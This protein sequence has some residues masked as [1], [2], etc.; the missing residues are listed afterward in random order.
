MGAPIMKSFNFK[1]QGN[2]VRG[3]AALVQEG[4]NESVY[5]NF[6]V[7]GF[8]RSDRT[9]AGRG[10]GGSCQDVDRS[11]R[12]HVY[13]S[14]QNDD[15]SGGFLFSHRGHDVHGGYEEAGAHRGE[16]TRHLHGDDS[17]RDRDRLCRRYGD[18][19]RASAWLCRRQKRRR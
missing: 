17:D 16:D 13:Q 5:S 15:R 18:R 12:H 7:I 14:D 6:P 19:G 1:G 10:C 4:R 3:A 11:D 8:I 2:G 9:D